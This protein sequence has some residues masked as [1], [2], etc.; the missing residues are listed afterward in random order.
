MIQLRV[1]YWLSWVNWLELTLF[2]FSAVFVWVFHTECLCPMPAQWQIGVV[3]VFLGWIELIIIIRKLPLTGIYVVMFLDIF[4][5]F[6]RLI[7]LS[8]LLVVAFGL[9]FY[10]CFYDPAFRV[11]YN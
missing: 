2:T 8:T 9:A 3:V 7:I 6:C 1:A 4:Y 11:R 10:M 5:T